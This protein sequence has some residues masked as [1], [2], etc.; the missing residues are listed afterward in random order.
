MAVMLYVRFPLSLRFR[1]IDMAPQTISAKVEYQFP[2]MAISQLGA[3]L[4]Y[5]YYYQGLTPTST[6]DPRSKSEK[7]GLLDAHLTL[8][9]IP[10][11]GGK[12]RLSTFGRNLADKEYYIAQF[13]TGTSSAFFDQSRT[14]GL[15][16]SFEY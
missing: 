2:P 14:Y 4:D 5:C 13:N 8:S 6:S 3:N 15:E 9:D 16:L 11:G 7:Y 12:W 1:F 10:I